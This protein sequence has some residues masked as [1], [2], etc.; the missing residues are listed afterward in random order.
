MSCETSFSLRSSREP[1]KTPEKKSE[2]EFFSMLLDTALI[3]LK[4]S[5]ESLHQHTE[6]LGFLYKFSELP[7]KEELIKHCSDFQLALTVVRMRILK[8]FLYMTN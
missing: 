5:F 1:V 6:P 7:K 3:S 2:I 4:E 8:E